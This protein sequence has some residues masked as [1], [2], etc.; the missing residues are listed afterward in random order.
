MED[1]QPPGL[2]A[3][4]WGGSVAGFSG[5]PAKQ[6]EAQLGRWPWEQDQ[7]E[8]GGSW[9]GSSAWP[10]LGTDRLPSGPACPGCGNGG[11]PGWPGSLHVT[12]SA[13]SSSGPAVLPRKRL[14]QMLFL[15]VRPEIQSCLAF[16]TCGPFPNRLG[17][18]PLPCLPSTPTPA[19]PAQ[20]RCSSSVGYC[21]GVRTGGSQPWCE[22]CS[23]LLS[24]LLSPGA[25]FHLSEGGLFLPRGPGGPMEL[26]CP[27]NV[28]GR[29]RLL[30]LE[31]VRLSTCEWRRGS[32]C[33]QPGPGGWQEKGGRP[34]T[35][36]EYSPHHHP[37]EALSTL[38]VLPPDTAACEAGSS[39]HFVGG[40]L[41]CTVLHRRPCG[42]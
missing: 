32:G 16:A 35:G 38:H 14:R 26:A 36:Q 28:L 9:G 31:I 41:K 12:G 19:F 1:C 10:E 4:Q 34:V 21:V 30:L 8:E 29:S 7:E 27:E 40:K 37:A 11:Q 17:C 18:L 33:G 6:Q 3:A 23:W 22:P 15:R 5:Q 13:G 42:C 20:S 24:R 25:S 2:W 39:P